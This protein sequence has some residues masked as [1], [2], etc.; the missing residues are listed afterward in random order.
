MPSCAARPRRPSGSAATAASSSAVVIQSCPSPAA[1]SAGKFVDARQCDTGFVCHWK[2]PPVSTSL[3]CANVRSQPTLPGRDL[4]D[5][6]R[7]QRVT[8]RQTKIGRGP[9]KFDRRGEIA[10]PGSVLRQRDAD[11][12]QP[13]PVTDG[14]VKCAGRLQIGQPDFDLV[15]A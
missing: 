7:T 10:D 6:L 2:Y 14:R 15:G 12:T 8:D 5:Q 13:D 4:A 1:A 9:K 11:I 3:C